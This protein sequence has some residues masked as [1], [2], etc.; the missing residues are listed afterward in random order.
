MPAA[1]SI[2]A[3][4][5]A[6]RRRLVAA[7]VT[8]ATQDARLL[9]QRVLGCDHAGLILQGERLLSAEEA[10]AFEALLLRRLGHE[11]VTKILG[12]RDFYGRV[13]RVTADVLDP[14]ADTETLIGLALEERAQRLLDLGSGSGALIV[15]LLAEWPEAT[16]VAVDLSPK[17]LAI[18]AENGERLGVG[19]RLTCLQGAWFAPVEGRFDLIVSN[20]PYIPSGDIAGLEPDVREHDPALALDGGA[21]G[22]SCYRAI[23]A[24]AAGHLLP[25]GRV[26]VEIGA[27]QGPDVAG[28][29]ALAGFRL[30]AERPDLGG[31]V[32]ALLF[33]LPR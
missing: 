13:F 21:D 3:A 19:K 29:F 9:M 15:T 12:E 5:A 18:T 8:D 24:E 22:L 28:I 23:A 33:T 14:R 2:T 30:G 20:P 16:G 27:G 26:I 11:P 6:A 31:H 4:L 17:A 25:G 7:D 10:I 32:R 1:E